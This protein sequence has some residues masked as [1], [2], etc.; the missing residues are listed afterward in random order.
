MSD[1][2]LRRPP[3]TLDGRSGL[4]YPRVPVNQRQLV[5]RSRERPVAPLANFVLCARCGQWW[6][7]G[8]RPAYTR[9][10]RLLPTTLSRAM[11]RDCSEPRCSGRQRSQSRGASICT[12][13]STGRHS[14]QIGVGDY[15]LFTA[16][17]ENGTGWIRR[18]RRIVPRDPLPAP[19][20][21]SRNSRFSQWH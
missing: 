16:P 18:L 14:A 13:S 3:F 8:P 17:R 12:G 1:H 10:R 2:G 5:A 4:L 7:P 20:N 6:C 19:V 21:R 11:R 15:T 9:C